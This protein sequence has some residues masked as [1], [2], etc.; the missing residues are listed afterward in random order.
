[1]QF[2]QTNKNTGDVNNT[3]RVVEYQVVY[4]LLLGNLINQ[5]NDMIKQGWEPQGGVSCQFCQAGGTVGHQYNQA[6]IKRAERV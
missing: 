2:N 5:V 1:M 4:T 6:M 3:E